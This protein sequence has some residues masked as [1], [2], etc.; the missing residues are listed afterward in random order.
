MRDIDSPSW[1]NSL[2]AMHVIEYIRKIT[3]VYPE[4]TSKDIGIITPYIKQV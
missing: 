2:E 1:Y 4:L 3:L